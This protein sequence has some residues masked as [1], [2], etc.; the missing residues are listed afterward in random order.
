[1]QSR[2]QQPDDDTGP[3]YGHVGPN[4]IIEIATHPYTDKS[5]DLVAEKYVTEQCT[6]VTRAEH[7]GDQ[8][9]C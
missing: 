2:R 7:R 1:M 8:A 9:R 3:P 4:C 5:T 6:N